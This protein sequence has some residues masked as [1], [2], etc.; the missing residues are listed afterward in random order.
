MYKN[1]SAHSHFNDLFFSALEQDF[2]YSDGLL[3]LDTKMMGQ[4]SI[5]AFLFQARGSVLL[6]SAKINGGSNVLPCA[7][8]DSNVII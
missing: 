5:L 3:A 2:V 7:H 4:R 8:D 1:S 6:Q